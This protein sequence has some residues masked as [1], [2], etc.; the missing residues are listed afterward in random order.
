MIIFVYRAAE[1]KHDHVKVQTAPPL[2]TGISE[3]SDDEVEEYARSVDL[4]GFDDNVS[5]SNT[6]GT[7]MRFV[8][9]QPI[10]LKTITDIP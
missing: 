2:E 6:I 7:L 4:P 9:G 8:I 5:P 1:T 3:L 10:T